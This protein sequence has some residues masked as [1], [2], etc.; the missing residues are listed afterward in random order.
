MVSLEERVDL[1]ER[2]KRK[3]HSVEQ[4]KEFEIV[5]QVD[6][7]LSA[8]SQHVLYPFVHFQRN[9]SS[10]TFNRRICTTNGVDFS[11]AKRVKIEA[12]RNSLKKDVHRPSVPQTPMRSTNTAP[13]NPFV[14]PQTKT[15]YY[16]PI[17]PSS[18]SSVRSRR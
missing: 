9:T 15:G 14:T 7:S 4:E 11:P 10:L 6:R 3:L 18:T 8:L 1:I 13:L 2:A 17:F 16:P 12:L 5:E